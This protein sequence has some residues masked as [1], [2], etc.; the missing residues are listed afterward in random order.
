MQEG[1]S[2]RL[3]SSSYLYC[4]SSAPCRTGPTAPAGVTCGPWAGRH[5][6]LAVL[7]WT[8][9]PAVLAMTLISTTGFIAGNLGDAV[10]SR[11]P[12]VDLGRELAPSRCRPGTGA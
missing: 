2:Y 6:G 1:P 5:R 11:A 7:V 8:M 10:A 3:S 4:C 12:V 9:W